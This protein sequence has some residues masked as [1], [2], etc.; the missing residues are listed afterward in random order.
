MFYGH[1]GELGSIFLL[2]GAIMHLNIVHLKGICGKKNNKHLVLFIL[3]NIILT[4]V[5]HV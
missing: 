4:F 5:H 3:L 1:M 2:F